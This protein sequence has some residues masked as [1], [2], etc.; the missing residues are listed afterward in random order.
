MKVKLYQID[1]F[2]VYII[3]SKDAFSN[4]HFKVNIISHITNIM[5]T[6]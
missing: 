4:V 1:M 3:L 2:H 6:R 5:S